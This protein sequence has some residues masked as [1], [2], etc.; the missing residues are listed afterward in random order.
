MKNESDLSSISMYINELKDRRTPFILYFETADCGVCHAIYPKLQRALN[1][2]E[3]EVV[4]INAIENAGI[5]GQHLV[6]T[7]PTVLLWTEGKEIL[8]ESRYIDLLKITRML[9]ALNEMSA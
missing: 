3:I 5:A 8:R 6:F 1:D 9:D 2:Y 4:K 7:V